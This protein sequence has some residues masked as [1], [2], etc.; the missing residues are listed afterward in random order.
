MSPGLKESTSNRVF[1]ENHHRTGEWATKISSTRNP[2]VRALWNFYSYK[3]SGINTLASQSSDSE[4]VLDL[5]SGNGVYSHWFI[6]RKPNCM[7]ID[8]DWSFEALKKIILPKKGLIKR[9][10]ADIHYLPFKPEIFD[11]VFSVDTL[12]HVSNVE[13]VL[14]ETL[15]VAKNGSKIF[16]H[17]ECSNYRYRWPDSMLIRKNGKDV[18]AEIDG[19]YNLKTSA[20][21]HVLYSRRFYIKSFFSPAGIFGWIIGYPEKYHEGFKNAHLLFFT[22]L[23]AI[24]TIIKKIPVLGILLR[25][26]NALTNHFELFLGLHGG[27]SC[28]AFLEKPDYNNFIRTKR[29]V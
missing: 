2:F 28:F 24:F 6:G 1:S 22:C 19:H 18:L 7:L 16:L 21:I 26:I 3:R 14:D 27:G 17:S 9:V 23:T 20:S 11:S 10:C 12:G 15:R 29:I 25:F 5:G 4:L 13:K 8:V